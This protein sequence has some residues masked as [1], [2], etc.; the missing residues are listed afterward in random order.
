MRNQI[1]Y[2]S[3]IDDLKEIANKLERIPSY[4]DVRKHGRYGVATYQRKLGPT[5]EDVKRKIGWIPK[6][7][8]IENF[9][10]T[11]Q[12][13]SWLSGIIDG[14]GCFRIAKPSPKSGLGLSKSYTPVFAI[15]IRMDDRNIID[16]FI[17]ILDIQKQSIHIDY[18]TGKSNSPNSNPA[19]KINIRDHPTLAYKLIPILEKY[20]L[21]SKKRNDFELFRIAINIYGERLFNGRKN[22][23]YSA[24]ERDALDKLYHALQEIKKYNAT[25]NSVIEKYDLQSIIEEHRIHPAPQNS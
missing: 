13:G 6:Y 16:E 5:W 2:N 10:V 21:R 15:S 3:L 20:P 8:L 9:T 11:P 19:Y 18:R 7:E 17:R 22:L 12:D 24:F 25:L 23:A 1:N 4:E 14:E